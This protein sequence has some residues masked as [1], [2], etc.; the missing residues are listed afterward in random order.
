MQSRYYQATEYPGLYKYTY[1]G[2]FAGEC[3]KHVIEA[4]NKFAEDNPGL[5]HVSKIPNYAAEEAYGTEFWEYKKGLRPKPTWAS[6]FFDHV[7]YYCTDQHW[8][9]I[10]SPYVSYDKYIF[11]P[12]RVR[13]GYDKHPC[14]YNDEAQT[15]ICRILKRKRYR[16]LT[17][18]LDPQQQAIDDA[19][20]T[21]LA[22]GWI[23][24]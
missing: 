5:K 17:P 19:H 8:I 12:C 20:E 10:T 22:E 11:E 4:R 3:S 6:G 9:V 21:A 7:E 13:L 24:E 1:W 2:N 16:V 14:M 15:F 18:D 23:D